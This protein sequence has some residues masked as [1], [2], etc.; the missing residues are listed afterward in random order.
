MSS[1]GSISLRIAT[2]LAI[3]VFV[4]SW[5]PLLRSGLSKES[6]SVAIVANTSSSTDS[7]HAAASRSS[8]TYGKLPISFEANQGQSD[9]SVQFLARG[10]G[11]TLYLTPGEA[12]LSLH[13]AHPN[14]K[15]P[16]AAVLANSRSNH[17]QVAASSH[18]TVR[19]RLIGA[20]TAAAPVGG[21]PLP[22]KSNYFIG[23]DP[24][25][26]HTDVPTYSRV[27]YSN[28]YPGIDL[29]Y[30]GN[31]EG[32]LEHDFVVAPGADPTVIAIALS[33]SP[34]HTPDEHGD[35]TLRTKN[36]DLTLRT[37]VA[38]Q[39]IDGQRKTVPATYMQ[40]ANNQI[41][42]QLGTYDKTAPLVID[43]VLKYSA[44]F[45]GGAYDAGY[46]IAVDS[47][48]NAYVTGG[49]NGDGFPGT[50]S[51]PSGGAYVSKINASG[52]ALLYST[53]L[54]G[55]FSWG[56]GIAADSAGRAH[57]VGITQEA[58][59]RVKNAYQP[60]FGGGTH[61]AFLA[62]LTP[63]GDDLVYSTYFGAESIGMAIALDASGNS[64]ITGSGQVPALH[65]VL[66]SATNGL[67]V[68]KFNSTGVL[69]YSSIFSAVG[70]PTNA[71]AV[72]SSGSAYVTGSVH[73]PGFPITK[74]VF[75][76]QCA[77]VRD[78]GCGF[79]TK[80]NP[81]GASL[82]YSTYFGHPAPNLPVVASAI[83][84]D[85]SGNA[86]IAGSTGPYFPVTS[87]AFQKTYGGN[88]DGY[89]TKLNASG[90][91]LL[92][93]TYLGGSAF[94]AVASLT[95]DQYRQ[96][97]V[98]GRT[99]SANFPL[100]SSLKP[101]PGS[102]AIFVTT[103]SASLDSI[104]YYSTYLGNSQYPTAITVDKALNVY[105]TGSGTSVLTP[106]TP[107]ALNIGT[108][109][110]PGGQYDVFVSKLVIMDDLALGISG[111][112][113]SVAHS[114]NFTYTIAVTS[115]GPDFGSNVRIDDP[116]PA[117]TTFVSYNAGGGICTAPA[118]GATGTLHCALTQ[119][120]KGQTYTVKLTVK[121]NA[122]SG[123]TL[124]NTATT[125]SNTQDFVS[126]NNKG[127]LTIKV[128]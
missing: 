59:V 124:S 38:Y 56:T 109:G 84:V 70:G 73:D 20:N 90:T 121:V 101:Y 12:V 8:S 24:A 17:G 106:P 71:I 11:Y 49:N 114:G 97:Y 69:Q 81:S 99:D 108:P 52:T 58:T 63:A 9:P 60:V 89:V 86:Y 19:L 13:A 62:V 45:G 57:V 82:A 37:P 66:P 123:S 91:G 96:V 41:K 112:S 98:V 126:S 31:Q 4:H 7:P 85:S 42:F 92:W 34:T 54:G 10:A 21:D 43:P 47:S 6:E 55:E 116:L 30:Y 104:V 79:A 33:D 64:Y 3:L 25:K 113:S 95:I 67:F 14:K 107:G 65:S 35:L 75:Q 88:I 68:A 16:G 110:N 36:G 5:N 32:K 94:D 103:L 111:S 40:A 29:V 72:D 50:P 61:N 77:I 76:S 120:N 102:A 115:K 22:G 44:L 26:W 119:L 125:V 117:G 46:A 74:N 122:A 1:L 2:A 15:L 100:K 51:E 78:F 39:T 18:S 83:A 48:G 28:I 118:V 53:Y 80:L 105:L 27:R 128:L 87:N 127:S 93:S 23:S